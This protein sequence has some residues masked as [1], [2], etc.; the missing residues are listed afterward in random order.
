MEWNDAVA[1]LITVSIHTY[2][3]APQLSMGLPLNFKPILSLDPGHRCATLLLPNSSLAILPFFQSTSDLDLYDDDYLKG[4]STSN[5][6]LSSHLPYSPSF[7]LNLNSISSSIVSN[8]VRDV[9]FLPGFQKPTLAILCQEQLTWTSSLIDRVDTCSIYMITLD[10]DLGSTKVGGGVHPI[11]M[12][13]KGLPYDSLYLRACPKS[14]GGVLLVTPSS[15]IHVDQESNVK[16]LA[17][18]NWLEHTT[19]LRLPHWQPR[20]DEHQARTI[21]TERDGSI[22]LQNSTLV[23]PNDGSEDQSNSSSSK[24]KSTDFKNEFEGEQDEKDS[25]TLKPHPSIALL[26]L[27]D[28]T[29]YSIQLKTEGRFLSGLNLFKLS[30][31]QSLLPSSTI[32]VLPRNNSEEKASVQTYIFC[33]S[34]AGEGSLIRVEAGES[35]PDPELDNEVNGITNVATSELLH[36]TQKVEDGM[37]LDDDLGEFWDVP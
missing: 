30:Q 9:V 15:L 22:D 24:G 12:E 34:L 36:P 19:K 8:N 11:L 3:R 6:N 21:S 23:F 25:K 32:S 2:E 17:V 31:H 20:P 18:N 27:A 7:V 14:I 33:G 28:G 4:T 13:R 26:F 10:L 16:G 29:V 37:D 35:T 5:D 1:D